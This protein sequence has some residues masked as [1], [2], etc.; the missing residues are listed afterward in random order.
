MLMDNLSALSGYNVQMK[1][2]NCNVKKENWNRYDFPFWKYFEEAT[3]AESLNDWNAKGKDIS[4]WST[5]A[6]AGANSVGDSQIVILV[7]DSLKQKMEADNEFAE[8]IMKKVNDWK[9]N[10]DRIDKAIGMSNGETLFEAEMA[11]KTG[12]YL[13]E[14]DEN[15]EVKNYTVTTHG[16]GYSSK[17]EPT[18]DLHIHEKEKTNKASIRVVDRKIMDISNNTM[19]KEPDYAVAMAILASGMLKK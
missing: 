3:T 6:Q 10:Y 7:P 5:Y 17:N 8:E 16:T 9:T 11:L 13:I 12:S 18:D 4:E 19:R 14:L 1:T 15:G 2:G